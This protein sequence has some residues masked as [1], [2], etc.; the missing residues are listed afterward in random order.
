MLYIPRK[1][2][3]SLAIALIAVLI[4]KA[5]WSRR[6]PFEQQQQQQQQQNSS[7]FVPAPPDYFKVFVV[8]LLGT[9][10]L[11]AF[12]DHSSSCS[13]SH[14]SSATSSRPLGGSAV[15][16]TGGGTGQTMRPADIDD[17]LKHIDLADP[18]F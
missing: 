11:C 8:A 13:P 9:Y 15:G 14:S 12:L 3:I 1:I 17:L 6:C 16:A 10:V 18:D 7:P 2:I 5:S 4:A